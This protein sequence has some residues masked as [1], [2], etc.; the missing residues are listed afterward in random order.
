M[1]TALHLILLPTLKELT[2]NQKPVVAYPKTIKFG[3]IELEG[4]MLENG[5]FRQSITSTERALGAEG[6]KIASRMLVPRSSN[7][8]PVLAAISQTSSA[9]MGLGEKTPE[10]AENGQTQAPVIIPVKCPGVQG[11]GAGAYTINL[12]MVVEIWKQ[13]A[14]GGGKYSKPALELLGLS[15]VHSLERTYQEAFGVQDERSTED[16][17]LDWAIRLEAGKHFPFFKGDFHKHFARVT[18]VTVGH[19]YAK[20]CLAELIYHR[21]PEKIYETLKDINPEDDRGYRQHTYSQLMTDEMRQYM[22]EVV[23][24]VTNQLANT[25]AKANDPKAYRKL[26][27]RLDKTLPRYNKRGHNPGVYPDHL[28]QL[29]DSQR[30]NKE[31]A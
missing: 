27:K 6:S 30:V 5:E 17:L 7:S 28:K 23:A 21:L 26:L 10:K 8:V 29:H 1:L 13:V 31:E 3:P 25:S 24:T 11:H 16:R 20:V 14:L 18:G 9:A 22:R 12:P 19:P 15:A 2:G 4:Y